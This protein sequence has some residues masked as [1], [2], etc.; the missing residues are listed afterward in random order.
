MHF[1]LD[2]KEKKTFAEEG[3]KVVKT[4]LFLKIRPIS[5]PFLLF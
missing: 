1:K 5:L 2:F 4:A 3:K